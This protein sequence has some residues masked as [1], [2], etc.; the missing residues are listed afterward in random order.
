[1]DDL[2]TFLQLL[3]LLLL[4][5]AFGAGAERL[6]QPSSVG[7]LIAGVAL[8]AVLALFGGALPFLGDMTDSDVLGGVAQ[9]GIFFLVLLA[10]IEMKPAAIAQSTRGALAIALGGMILPLAGGIGLGWLILPESEL[11]PALAMVVGVS[12]AITAIP[13]TAKVLSEFGLLHTPL[14]EMVISAAIFDDVFAL[15]LLAVLTAFVQTGHVPDPWVLVWL[16]AKVA[17]FFAITI[18]LGVH[19]Y[20]RISRRIGAMEAATLELSAIVALGLGYGWLA[21]FLGMHWI[22]GAFMAGLYFEES[23]VGARAYGDLKLIVSAL[24]GG[25]LGPMFFAWIGLQVDLRAVAAI[26]G[27][28]LAL[29][30]VAFLSKLVGAGL[31]ALWIGLDR[32]QALSV[33]VGMSARGAMELVVL[34]IVLEAGL[35]ERAG[36]TD[37]VTAHL[38]SALVIMAMVTT[39]LVPIALRRLVRR[40]APK[41]PPS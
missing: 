27:I 35:F 24:T 9:V 6:G 2:E 3:V 39:L 8:A 33:G 20:P 1:M 15:F 5:R 30:L 16:L 25:L 21:E 11:K 23:R 34:S 22:M 36:T 29:I 41:V 38:F 31:P 26:P 32:R 4:A 14:G 7:E 28:V 40:E 18:V 17:A 10:G 37:A 12:M 13:A 19:L